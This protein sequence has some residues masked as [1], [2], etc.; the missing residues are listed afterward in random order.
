MSEPNPET[1][2]AKLEVYQFYVELRR[3]SPAVWRRILMR[4]DSS[5]YDLHYTLQLAFGWSDNHLNRF[6]IHN[7]EYG[8]YK[9]GGTCF[10][11]DAKQV[12][13]TDLKLRPAQRFWYEYDFGDRWYHDLRLEKKLPIM[14]KKIYPICVTG[15][16]KTPPEDCGGAWAYMEL[17]RE[18]SLVGIE[19]RM[20][21]ILYEIAEGLKEGQDPH[22]VSY[23][24]EEVQELQ[25]WLEQ[26]KNEFDRKAVNLHLRQFAL[27]QE[28]WWWGL[29]G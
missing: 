9:G 2:Q 18:H 25:Q 27:G 8:V 23:Y 16:G 10:D 5:I 22:F 12:K 17:L 3:V 6:F 11:E 15:K 21:D 4:S 20:A 28:D 1:S 7:K 13:L 26:H 14:P 19:L 24:E 29:T